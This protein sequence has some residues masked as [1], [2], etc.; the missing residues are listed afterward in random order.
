MFGPELF[1]FLDQLA[2][3]N[4]REWFQ[5]NRSRFEE[6]VRAPVLRFIEAF[7]PR[8]HRISDRFVA[9]SRPSGGSM[10]RIHRDTRFSRDKSPYKT[11]VAV[12]FRHVQGR[13]VHAP[14]FYLH[15]QPGNTFAGAG[16]WHPDRTVLA[17]V[18]EA[19]A[20]TPDRWRHAVGGRTFRARFE[21]TGD[22]LKRVPRGFPADHPAADELRR[23]DFI[24]LTRFDDDELFATTFLTS[25]A[26][27]FRLAVPMMQFLT[28][29]M[30][31]PW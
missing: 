9:D 6:D 26:G 16:L 4:R 10:F 1:A 21:R 5:A 12:Q 24:A 11:W 31:L 8:L 23:K 19:I 28:N 14:G 22:A 17:Q 2:R 20:D 25:L 27:R 13:D 7:A 30:A 18:R 3:N 15:I 29:A